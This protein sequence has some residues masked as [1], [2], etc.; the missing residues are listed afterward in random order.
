MR[1]V[2]RAAL[3]ALLVGCSA[4]DLSPSPVV[5]GGAA[6]CKSDDDCDAQPVLRDAMSLFYPPPVR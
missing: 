1:L 3:L 2:P 6:T 5:D 4:E